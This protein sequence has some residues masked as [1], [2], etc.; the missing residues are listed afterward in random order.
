MPRSDKGMIEG[1]TPLF[2]KRKATGERLATPFPRAPRVA[3]PVSRSTGTR[4]PSD[5]PVSTINAPSAPAPAER[6]RLLSSY[7]NHISPLFSCLLAER[8]ALPPVP[9]RCFLI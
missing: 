6:S 5:P 8:N 9:G 7:L 2:E 4:Y 1:S 3:F